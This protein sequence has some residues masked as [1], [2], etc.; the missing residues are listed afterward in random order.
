M[1]KKYVF[2]FKRMRQ[3]LSEM[4]GISNFH[5]FMF[6]VKK[7]KCSDKKKIKKLFTT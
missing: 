1:R 3:S 5:L 4:L 7:V 6:I 2:G